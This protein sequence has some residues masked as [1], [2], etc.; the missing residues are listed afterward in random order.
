MSPEDEARRSWQSSGS[1]SALPPLEEL[2]TRA[3]TF[4]RKIQRRNLIEYLAGVL[5][6]LGFGWMVIVGPLP[7][8]PAVIP[9]AIIRLGS[10]LVMIGTVFTLW[11]LHRRTAPLDPPVDGGRNSVLDYQRAELVR[12]R[13]AIDSV[14][15]WYILP[16]V[17]GLAVLLLAPL[18]L[19][20]QIGELSWFK[21]VLKVSLAPLVF[22]AVWWLNKLGAR[23]LQAMI[24]EIDALRRE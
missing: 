3:D 10:A 21:V 14:F 16:F 24:D 20:P 7:W 15:Y 8:T 18:A 9:A 1:A 17:P 22:A 13:D 6:L 5:V 4:R 23:K 2:R 11:Q 12:Q 19:S